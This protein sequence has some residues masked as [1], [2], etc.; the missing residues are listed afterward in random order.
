MQRASDA[1]KSSF[2]QFGVFSPR[3]S[4]GHKLELKQIQDVQLEL[5]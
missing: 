2:Y 5:K 3:T 4:Q 1:E